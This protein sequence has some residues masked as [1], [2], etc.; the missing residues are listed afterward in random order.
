VVVAAAGLLAVLAARAAVVLAA[1]AQAQVQQRQR[2]LRQVA[3]AQGQP[4]QVLAAALVAQQLS[5]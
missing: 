5:T 1:R 3:V 2:I 4:K